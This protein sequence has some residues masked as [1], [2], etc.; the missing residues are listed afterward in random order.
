MFIQ[1]TAATDPKVAAE[2]LKLAFPEF[3]GTSRAREITR[4]EEPGDEP[5]V[6]VTADDVAAVIRILRAN[7][8]WDGADG[9]DGELEGHP[10]G[11][12]A[13]SGTGSNSAGKGAE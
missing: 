3:F 12:S 4:S 8:L 5:E 2:F 9:L 13:S 6:D 7:G 10:N 1:Q 11:R